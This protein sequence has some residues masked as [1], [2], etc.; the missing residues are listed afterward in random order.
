MLKVTANALG[1]IKGI[2]L[3]IVEKYATFEASATFTW[4]NSIESNILGQS[5]FDKLKKNNAIAIP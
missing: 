4:T 3:T 5:S 1:N 2:N